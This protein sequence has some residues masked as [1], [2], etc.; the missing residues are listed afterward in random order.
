MSSPILVP[1]KTWSWEPSF[2]NTTTS[3]DTTV[4]T[5]YFA[6]W[7]GHWKRTR[8]HGE[9]GWHWSKFMGSWTH[10]LCPMIHGQTQVATMR[11]VHRQQWAGQLKGLLSSGRMQCSPQWKQTGI[12]LPPCACGLEYSAVSPNGSHFPKFRHLIPDTIDF[13][14]PSYSCSLPKWLSSPPILCYM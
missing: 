13:L 6:V 9:F 7:P 11:Q 4:V 8:Q 14:W 2:P 3:P 5:C 1:P 10:P 12:C